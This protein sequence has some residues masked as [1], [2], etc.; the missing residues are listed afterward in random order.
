[1]TAQQTDYSADMDIGAKKGK[2]GRKGGK[3]IMEKG[4][5]VQR[6]RRG[7]RQRNVHGRG[8]GKKK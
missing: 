7:Q 8:N 4:V 5:N 3:D 2:K 1:M 6:R